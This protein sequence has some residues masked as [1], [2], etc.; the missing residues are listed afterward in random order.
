MVS[1]VEVQQVSK[2][3]LG[4]E[5]TYQAGMTLPLGVLVYAI[6][7]PFFFGTVKKF[8]QKL[9][10]TH[11]DS[12]ILIIRLRRVPFMDVAGLQALGK[13]I[14]N[15]EARGIRATLCEANKRVRENLD[16]AGI[17]AAIEPVDYLDDFAAAVARC[18]ALVNSSSQMAHERQVAL[19][20]YAENFLKISESYLFGTPKKQG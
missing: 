19:S 1:Y 18:D 9:A 2:K 11:T 6:D 14:L 7:G 4:M 16:K 20:E 13:A 15:L 8:E 10:Q 12:R 17:L 3:E 5:L